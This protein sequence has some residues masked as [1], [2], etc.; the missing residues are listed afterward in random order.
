MDSLNFGVMVIDANEQIIYCNRKEAELRGVEANSIIGKSIYDCHPPH[1]WEQIT[2]IIAELKGRGN[3]SSNQLRHRGGLFV[4]QWIIPVFSQD[5]YVGLVMTS[6]DVTAREN[7]ARQY[8]DMVTIDKLTGLFNKNHFS[9]VFEEMINNLG[10][11]YQSLALM[12][13]DCNWLKEVNDYLGHAAGD[14][15]LIKAAELIRSSIRDTDLAFRIGGDEFAV[16][17]PNGNEAGAQAVRERISQAT[18]NWSQANPDLPVS[19]AIGWKIASDILE[20]DSLFKAAD[21]AM[22]QDKQRIKK[23]KQG[24]GIRK[25]E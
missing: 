18:D 23:A 14:Q 1:A 16:I 22:Y 20:I 6:L 2:K 9:M 4:E 3:N 15:V 11:D 8:A 17:M 10:R 24:L 7:K 5:I 12:I 21:N 13:I 25:K 19:L